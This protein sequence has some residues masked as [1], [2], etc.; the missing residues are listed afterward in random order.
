M[1]NPYQ[2][3]CNKQFRSY[4]A[5]H[6]NDQTGIPGLQIDEKVIDYDSSKAEMFNSYFSSVFT[7]EDDSSSPFPN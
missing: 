6:R 3:T 1:L 5:S 2:N 7:K 4:I